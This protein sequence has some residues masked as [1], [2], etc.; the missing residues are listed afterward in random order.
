MGR[1]DI[2]LRRNKMTSRR[3]GSHKNYQEILSR[4]KGQPKKKVGR[5]IIFA[6]VILIL[7]VVTFYIFSKLN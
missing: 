3:I 5:G 2:R 7:V 6:V 4:H 1:H